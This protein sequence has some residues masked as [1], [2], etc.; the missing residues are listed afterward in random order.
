MNDLSL[1]ESAWRASGSAHPKGVLQR[2]W[3]SGSE[4]CRAE[5]VSGRVTRYEMASNLAIHVL[6]SSKKGS[7]WAVR[8]ACFEEFSGLS[9]LQKDSEYYFSTLATQKDVQV[10]S[11]AKDA[12]DDAWKQG[13]DAELAA[14]LPALIFHR[15]WHSMRVLFK[16]GIVFDGVVT[17]S[18]GRIAWDGSPLP[19]AWCDESG[20]TFSPF[21]RIDERLTFYHAGCAYRRRHIVR[22]SG[23]IDPCPDDEVLCDEILRLDGSRL[24]AMK[25]GNIDAIFLSPH[26][27]YELLCEILPAFCLSDAH[28]LSFSSLFSKEMDEAKHDFQILCDPLS[29]LFRHKSEPLD[30]R[31]KST[32]KV[33]LYA[34]GCPAGLV[35][36]DVP[37]KLPSSASQPAWA[38]LIRKQTP[39]GHAI[40]AVG[41]PHVFYPVI[42]PSSESAFP[43]FD[44]SLI[45][46]TAQRVL[47]IETIR[48][49]HTGDSTG[50]AFVYV[51]EGG[52]LYVDGCAY[53]YVQPFRIE[54]SIEMLLRSLDVVSSPELCCGAGVC[55]LSLDMSGIF[56]RLIV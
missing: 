33:T 2:L 47:V 49:I 13:Y 6:R 30:A 56:D 44:R 9:L 22:S 8:E 1:Y 25:P 15:L 38:H 7:A 28:H 51:P 19:F 54:I 17:W 32:Q 52:V 3:A 43:K 20:A 40:D 21:P 34:H 55:A 35:S 4:Q 14:G 24:V 39:N 42:C 18:N 31:G 41:T 53:G 12:Y 26:A 37:V 36:S 45:G 10:A 5:F 11:E 16:R 48:F 50:R 46:R 23:S 29:P 27:A